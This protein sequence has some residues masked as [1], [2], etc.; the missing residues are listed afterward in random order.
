M[1]TMSPQERKATLR[2]FYAVIY[3]SLKQLEGNLAGDRS[4]CS[5]NLSRV[6]DEGEDDECGICM[7]SGANMVLPNCAHSMCINCFHHWYIRSQS[8]P[9]CRG[10]LKRVESGD[11]WVLTA[12]SDV[13]DTIT[14]AHHNLKH[15]YLYIDKLPGV[16]SETN[17]SFYDYLM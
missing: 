9:F 8:C 2:D 12:N 5:G 4:R 3:P 15:F 6:V 13:V 7:E 1:P 16:V 14:L 17:A 10:S 11:L